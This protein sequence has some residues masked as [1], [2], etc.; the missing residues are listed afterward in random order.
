MKSI[1]EF[2][3]DWTRGKVLFLVLLVGVS[4]TS[5]GVMFYV[6]SLPDVR[7]GYLG[8]DLHQLAYYVAVKQGFYQE[9]GLTVEGIS[10][11]NG[12]EVMTSFESL[13]RPIDMAYLGFAPAITH[14]FTVATAKI[15]VLAEANVNGTSIIVDT[16][17]NSML[18][19]AGK[20]V[21]IPARNNMQDFILRMALDNAGM[22]YTDV[23]TW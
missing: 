6:N 3:M 10:Y 17:I 9:E 1:G 2:I 8:G 5:I 12:G 7:I 19:L 18:D 22:Q 21:A 13:N 16:S 11:A 15:T 14:R 23:I 4:G 20:K